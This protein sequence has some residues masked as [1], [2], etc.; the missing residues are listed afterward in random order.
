MDLNLK[1]ADHVLIAELSGKLTLRE[2][3]KVCTLACDGAAERGFSAFLLDASA[4][5]GEL[6][7]LERYKLGKIVAEYCVSHSWSYIV[8]LLGTEPAVTGFGALVASNRGLVA[9]QFRERE[10][11]L[12][13]L[14]AFVSGP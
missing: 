11:A 12:A 9:T 2:A 14:D 3:L 13:W 1:I 4:V 5:D 6:S 10:K 8:A 7:V